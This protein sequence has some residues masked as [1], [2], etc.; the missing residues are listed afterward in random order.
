MD[1]HISDIVIDSLSDKAPDR[2]YYTKGVD[3]T[4][5]DYHV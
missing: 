1:I 3:V 4:I 5:H 2:F